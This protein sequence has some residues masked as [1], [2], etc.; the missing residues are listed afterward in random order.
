MVAVQVKT[1][2]AQGEQTGKPLRGCLAVRE[3]V[4]GSCQNESHRNE[5]PD[6]TQWDPR[7]LAIR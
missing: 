3:G 5:V 7:H 1:S 4:E 6:G 2:E